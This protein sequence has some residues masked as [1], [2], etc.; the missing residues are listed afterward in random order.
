MIQAIFFDFNG[1]IIN[2]ERI[3]LKAYREVFQEKGISLT[4]E[5]YYPCLGMDDVAFVRAAYARA[6]QSVDDLTVRETI[7]REHALHREFIKQDLPVS[8]GVHIT[9]VSTPRRDLRQ[10]VQR[11]S[12][13]E[14]DAEE[15]ERAA[16]RLRRRQSAS[17]S[18]Y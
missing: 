11:Q 7:E 8:S 15:Y 16:S 12:H 2:D 18:P 13:L 6:N 1:V 5:E 9:E 3:H 10:S 14:L 17:T 4:D